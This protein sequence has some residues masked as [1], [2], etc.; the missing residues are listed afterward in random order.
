MFPAPGVRYPD[1]RYPRLWDPIFLDA[2][3][4]RCRPS[5]QWMQAGRRFKRPHERRPVSGAISLI[6][7]APS[8]SGPASRRS[9]S[10]PLKYDFE[11]DPPV[12][13]AAAK[14]GKPLQFADVAGKRVLLHLSQR[15]Q[16]P[17]SVTRWDAF[18]SLFCWPGQ[19]DDPFHRGIPRVL[20]SSRVCKRLPR[21]DKRA[22]HWL[23]AIRQED[24]AQ[25]G[26][27]ST[28]RA[29][30]PNACDSLP[31]ALARPAQP[32]QAATRR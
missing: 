2:R 14:T 25:T 11:Q 28:P 15:S 8:R 10:S 7:F 20:R 27:T 3:L 6:R 9:R 19:D 4:Q 5:G 17:R 18:K 22:L 31:F 23:W 29:R 1:P 21:G 24:V 12:T 16:D 32:W 30:V 26:K 13:H